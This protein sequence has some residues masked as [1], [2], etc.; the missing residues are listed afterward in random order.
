MSKLWNNTCTTRIAQR[1]LA[2][3]HNIRDNVCVQPKRGVYRNCGHVFLR[4]RKRL[5]LSNSW[6]RYLNGCRT[7]WYFG[8]QSKPCSLVYH[9]DSPAKLL[10]RTRFLPSRPQIRGTRIDLLLD[11]ENDLTLV[12]QLSS[13]LV[14]F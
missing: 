9:D 4:H 2:H 3:Q 12:K 11:H 8:P 13:T 10:A 5:G 1:L 7:S 14:K 6:T